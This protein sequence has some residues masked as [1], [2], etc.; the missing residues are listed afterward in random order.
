MRWLSPLALVAALASCSGPAGDDQARDANAALANEAAA[1]LPVERPGPATNQAAVE[2]AA[3]IPLIGE[4]I[5]LAEWRKADNW[6]D[7]APLALASHAGGEGSARRAHFSGGWA[8]AFDR[9]NLRSAFG[10]A[11]SGLLPDD[12]ADQAAKVAALEEQ[13]PYIRRFAA[14]ENLPAGSVAGY[15]LEGAQRYSAANPDGR[16]QDSLAYL[17]IPGQACQYNVW[18]KLGRAHLEALLGHLRIVETGRR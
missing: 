9:P 11:G 14:G 1:T 5:V 15:G 8:V 6:G 3:P 17:R 2:P 13:W 10:V 18:S 16:E 12:R 7:C 4:S